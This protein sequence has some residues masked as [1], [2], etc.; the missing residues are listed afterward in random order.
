MRVD[1]LS[2][3]AIAEVVPEVARLRIAVFRDWP[4]L[5]DGDEAYERGYL[6]GYAAAPDAVV[7]IARAGGR[8]VGAATGMGLEG[9]G[10]D[11][12]GPMAAA[13]Y[14][15][16]RTFYC[17]ESVLLPQHR[18]RGLG[19]AFFDAREGHA[20]A[21]GRSAACFCAVVR[22][23]GHPMRPPDARPLEPFWRGRGYAPVGAMARIAWRDVGEGAETAKELRFWARPL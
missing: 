6:G 13:G 4:Y 22:P 10:A 1:I 8:I 14:A 9:Q 17:A 21:A 7:V 16:N 3:P 11:V 5:Y 2:G 19:H 12:S 15:P 20:R 18:G 23:E